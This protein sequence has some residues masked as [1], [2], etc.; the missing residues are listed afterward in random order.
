MM[1]A[2]GSIALIGFMGAGKSRIGAALGARLVMPV[3]DTDAAI[4]AQFGPI[5]EIFAV[6]GEEWFRE[7]ERDVCVAA[8]AEALKRPSVIALGGGAVTDADVRAALARC[9]HV[10]WLTA[11]V[12]VLFERASRSGRVGD[13]PGIR[14]LARDESAFRRLHAQREP[15]YMECATLVVENDGTRSVDAVVDEL[16]HDLASDRRMAG[17]S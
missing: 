9:A 6:R 5:E 4:V 8:L 1:S 16:V 11:P 17:G 14:P 12:T 3:T 10:A 2:V 13:A 15:L 7:Q